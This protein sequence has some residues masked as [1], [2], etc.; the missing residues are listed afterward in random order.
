[1]KTSLWWH[2]RNF[3]DSNAFYGVLI[4]IFFFSFLEEFREFR[5]SVGDNIF[6][7]TLSATVVPF[8]EKCPICGIKVTV[9]A[10]VACLFTEH[11][12]ECYSFSGV[13]WG[14]CLVF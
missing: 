14:F 8:N 10:S 5:E 13:V 7:I 6:H 1:M 2:I 12:Y 9:C 11:F 3:I 4:H